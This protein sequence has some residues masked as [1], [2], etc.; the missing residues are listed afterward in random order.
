MTGNEGLSTESMDF[1][2]E[3]EGYVSPKGRTVDDHIRALKSAYGNCYRNGYAKVNSEFVDEMIHCLEWYSDK[4]KEL[5]NE[6]DEEGED[7][8]EEEKTETE[9]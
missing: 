9:E 7:H 6:R 5:E 8:D 4:V 3:T 2:V 1:V